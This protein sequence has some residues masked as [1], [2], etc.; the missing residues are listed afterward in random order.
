MPDRTVSP[1][2]IEVAAD[3]EPFVDFIEAHFDP[4]FYLS[5][6]IDVAKAGI[7]ATEHF[8]RHGIGENRPF[9]PC[10][11]MHYG[12]DASL[13]LDRTW[14]TFRWRG[15]PIAVR[16]V[17]GQARDVPAADGE[18][19]PFL[20][21]IGRAFGRRRL[22]II[23]QVGN[24]FESIGRSEHIRT[25]WRALRAASVQ[26]TVYDVYGRVP[27]DSVFA[28][29][30]HCRVD[31]VADGIRIFHLN[32]AE[33]Q[34]ALPKIEE[35][36]P[37][38]LRR[39]YNVLAPAWELPR[40]PIEWAKEFN[41]FHEIWAPTAFVQ[42]ALQRAVSAPI[43]RLPNACEPHVATN[44]D[45][46]YFGIPQDSFAILNFFDL[47]SST[48]RKNPWAV[49]EAFRR[50]LTARPTS[51]AFLVLKINYPAFDPK[52][53]ANLA[54]EV[55]QIRDHA[56]LIDKAIT[57]NEIR[58][59]V[60]CC[61]CFISLHRSEGFGRGPAEAMFFG[62]PVVATGWSGNMEYMNDKVAF[63][64]RY[65]LRPVKEGEYPQ[66]EDQVWAEADVAHA[67]EVLIRLLDDPALR[68]KIGE[69][70]RRHM[71]RQYSDKIVGASYRRRIEA[72]LDGPG[73]MFRN[74]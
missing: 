12:V 43:F 9:S 45:K 16:L 3:E 69:R 39:G 6:N 28:E 55:R 51:N 25:F 72:I 2:Q 23:A 27:E 17:S 34:Y 26:A 8:F 71:E 21:R 74:T 56:I 11:D 62:R 53:V 36:Q 66:H 49:L 41:R 37:G 30:G 70:G 73:C 33:M 31:W 67:A 10:V 48:A 50:L 52:V 38:F 5:K 61:D 60:R 65:T 14:N 57:T 20:A 35:R 29:M 68:R 63:P 58:N 13:S 18:T 47:R 40:F 64:I 19:R 42:D 46:S 7:D 44:L 4:D 15:N 59:L 32:G 22:P 24:P 54:A 1:A